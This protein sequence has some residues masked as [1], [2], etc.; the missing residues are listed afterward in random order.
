MCKNIFF[1][2][3]NIFEQRR[4]TSSTCYIK[5]EKKTPIREVYRTKFGGFPYA[6]LCI[7][8]KL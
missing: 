5:E 6:A 7:F 4:L 3:E 2:N 8:G 1:E